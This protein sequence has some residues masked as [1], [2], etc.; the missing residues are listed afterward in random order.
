M[1]C[2]FG[3]IF[4]RM[5]TTITGPASL[6]MQFFNPFISFLGDFFHTFVDILANFLESIVGVLT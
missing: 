1:L 2:P 3:S 5:I 4:E 6:F